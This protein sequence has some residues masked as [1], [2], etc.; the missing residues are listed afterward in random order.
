M[1]PDLERLEHVHSPVPPART[2]AAART[3]SLE[4]LLV[5]VTLAHPLRLPRRLLSCYLGATTD[6]LFAYHKSGE[7]ARIH[8][9][10]IVKISLLTVYSPLELMLE[11]EDSSSWAG[12]GTST[13]RPP[14][15]TPHGRAQV[16]IGGG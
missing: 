9:F 2:Q 15:T 5:G 1:C 11:P 12:W 7:V 3:V 16:R 13:R 8:I 14:A 10:A 6:G 4:E